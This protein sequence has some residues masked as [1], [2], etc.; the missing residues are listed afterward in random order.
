MA[1]DP[2][3]DLGFRTAHQKMAETLRENGTEPDYSFN[4]L[5][6]LEELLSVYGSRGD[7]PGADEEGLRDLRVRAAA[8]VAEALLRTVPGAELSLKGRELTLTFPT[9]VPGL[10]LDVFPRQRVGKVLRGEE[11]LLDW[12]V[13]IEAMSKQS[14]AGSES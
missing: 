6:G 3:L 9:C 12:M 11:R 5:S 7:A 10:T 8:Y 2:L 13:F 4:S 14:S 1:L